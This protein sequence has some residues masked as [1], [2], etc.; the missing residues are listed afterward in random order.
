LVQLVSFKRES[1]IQ[2]ME[3]LLA[4]REPPSAIF[5]ANNLLGEMAMFAVRAHGLRMPEDISLL[6]F[7]DVPWA[8][9]T[10]PQITVVAQ[11]ISGLGSCAVEQLIM[12]L[13]NPNA[14]VQEGRTVVLEAEL[15][16]R[17]SCAPPRL[18]VM[19]LDG[20]SD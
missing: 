8:S 12:R 15:I 17:E 9:F 18:P 7:D 13:Q 3:Q 1:G 10:T 6:M 16:V 14:P 2:A 4:L 5:A 20:H 19:G 11:P